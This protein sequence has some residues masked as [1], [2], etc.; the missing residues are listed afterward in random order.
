MSRARQLGAFVFVPFLAAC[1]LFP[2]PRP[3]DQAPR[4]T[5]TAADA[6]ADQEGRSLEEEE[7]VFEGLAE[8]ESAGGGDPIA[9]LIAGLAA[10]EGDAARA[11]GAPSTA[12]PHDDVDTGTGGAP[13]ESAEAPKGAEPTACDVWSMTDD[14]CRA[15]LAAAG[16]AVSQPD[17][18]TPFIRQPLLLDGPIDGVTIRPRWRREVR[19]NEVMDCRLIAVLRGVARAARELGFLELL[20]YSTYRPIQE[21]PAECPKG[22]S[23]KKCGKA[24]AAWD[25]AKAGKASMHRRGLA[26]DVGWLTT[27]DGVAVEVLE[28]YERHSG[29]PPCDAAA[30]T[31]VGRRLRDFACALHAGKLFNVV[32]TPNANKAHHNHFHLDVTPNARWYIIR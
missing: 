21:P 4:E 16:I 17:F 28:S 6:G 23:G 15:S 3:T 24:R 29:D 14:A 1:S 7:V 25:K 19:V 27:A 13:A 32:L 12:Q 5:A 11:G 10:P 31:D 9:E 20:F 26:I 30:D 2:P 8:G 22:A 18:E